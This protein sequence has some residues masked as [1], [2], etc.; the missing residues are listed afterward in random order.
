MAE[1]KSVSIVLCTYNGAKYLQEQLDSILAQTYPLHEIIIQDDGS[2]DNTWQ[3]LEEY[4][5]KYPLIHIYHNEGTHGV[6]AN[7]LSAMHRTTGDF[8]AIADQDDIWEADKIAYQM[9]TIGNKLLCS[10]L[11]RPFSTD[12]SFAYFDNRPRNVSIFRMMFLGLPGHTML[13][14]RELL[15]MMPPVTYPF[16]NVSLYDAALSILAASHDSI[17]FCNKVLVNFRRHADATTYNDYSRS[18]PS[19][20]NGLYELLWG[21]RHYHQARSIAL[22]IYKGKL[23]FMEGITTNY[24]DFI[25]A[26]AIMKLETKKGLWAFLRLQYLLTKNHQRLFQTSGGSFIKMIRAWLYPVMQ[27]YMYHHALRRC[28]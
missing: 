19:W 6:N 7:F 3:I 20:Q 17:A 26:K 12:G 13:F 18:L 9:T 11:T 10:G 5:E 25:E 4:E 22:P 21:L 15:R 1:K 28:K 2:T 8:I 23:A 16:F 14:R 24:H 27:L